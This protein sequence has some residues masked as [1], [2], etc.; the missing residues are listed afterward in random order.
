MRF[1]Q[2]DG[3]P[4]SSYNPLEYNRYTYVA[5]NPVNATDATGHAQ[6]C[7]DYCSTPSRRGVT[8]ADQR[9]LS[10]MAA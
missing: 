3:M 5:G 6:W 9:L 10:P 4:A 2:R 1:T 7:D 8:P